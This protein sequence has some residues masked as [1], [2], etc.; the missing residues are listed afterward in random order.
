MFMYSTY[1]QAFVFDRDTAITRQQQDNTRWDGMSIRNKERI[2]GFEMRVIKRKTSEQRK[3]EATLVD[4]QKAKKKL[5]E[6]SD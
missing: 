5:S 6:E 2:L 4:E 1:L 3:T